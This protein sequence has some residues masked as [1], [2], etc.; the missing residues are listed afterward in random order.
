[1]VSQ[2]MAA[3]VWPGEDPIGKRVRIWG[4]WRQVVGVVGDVRSQNPTTP[5]NWQV[6]APAAQEPTW[7]RAAT[8]ALRASTDDTMGLARAVRREIA[9]LDPMLAVSNVQKMDDVVSRSIGPWRLM[10]GLMSAFA[11]LAA[12]LAAIG[13]YGLIAY[14]VGQR[15]WEF[16]V[17]MALGADRAVVMRL[18]LA[19]GMKLAAAGVAIG[20]LAGAGLARLMTGLLYQVTPNDPW[21][22]GAT[23]LAAIVAA[24][25]A[26]YV[27]AR[28]AARVDPIVTL[29]AL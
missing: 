29:R 26:C 4:T 16:G 3:K 15:A 14:T 21:V 13:T 25:A 17:R 1:L 7:A 8:F 9:A 19:K 20:A 12:L 2:S 11:V 27:P 22:L 18:V 23:C 28:A 24:L 6:E 10:S 5:A